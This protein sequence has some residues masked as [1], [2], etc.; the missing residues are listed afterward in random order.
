[1]AL[2]A[3]TRVIILDEDSNLPGAF[4]AGC[5][6]LLLGVERDH[7]LNRAA[8]NIGMAYSKA[9]RILKEAE[10]QLGVQLLNRNGARGS[11]L[12]EAGKRALQSYETL[13][14]EIEELANRRMP[15]LFGDL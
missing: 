6:Q 10:A 7:S 11:E 4:G 9:W 1:M 8:K 13:T 2:K 5:V 3:S 12:T 14:S 15:E